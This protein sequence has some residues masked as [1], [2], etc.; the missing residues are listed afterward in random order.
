MRVGV[1]AGNFFIDI[2]QTET[3]SCGKKLP[4]NRQENDVAGQ[5]DTFAIILR[6]RLAVSV[7]QGGLIGAWFYFLAP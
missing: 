1:L 7:R 4:A 5:S 2:K 3:S 6:A